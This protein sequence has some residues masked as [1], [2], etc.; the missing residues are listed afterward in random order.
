MKDAKR[1]KV[2][3]DIKD[4]TIDMIT[5]RRANTQI[6]LVMQRE[7]KIIAYIRLIN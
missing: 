6:R 4:S 2:M 3:N 1:Q 7:Q 5:Y